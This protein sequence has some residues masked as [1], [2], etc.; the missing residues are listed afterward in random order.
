MRSGPRTTSDEDGASN[1]DASYSGAPDSQNEVPSEASMSE[2]SGDQVIGN[3]PQNTNA[4]TLARTLASNLQLPNLQP[5]QHA[6]LF[7]LSLI[8]GRCRTQAAN[9]VNSGRRAEDHLADDHPDVHDLAEVLFTKVSRELRQA[10][11]LPQELVIPSL[12]DLRRYSN[13]FD[14]LLLSNIATQQPPN[15]FE[16]SAFRAIATDRNTLNP[17]SLGSDGASSLFE[18]SQQ[19]PSN[20]YDHGAYRTITDSNLFSRTGD[21]ASSL[22]DRSESQALIAQAFGYN[23][24]PQQLYL[25]NLMV[26]SSVQQGSRDSNYARKFKEL[27]RLGKGGFGEVYRTQHF[28]D[29]QYYAV[30]KI[31]IT[32]AQLRSISSEVDAKP[33]LAELRALAHL[34]QRNVVRYFDSWI[35]TR[36]AARMGQGLISNEAYNSM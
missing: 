36:P 29:G 13:S 9:S 10:G 22:F 16:Q 21:A 19:Q 5:H 24:P 27:D 31:R 7:Y 1:M 3:V 17:V 4:G 28:L 6:S 25:S 23:M 11:M 34:Q 26:P 2:A 30:K 18:R 14:A 20:L 15:L 32:A 35:E 33:L 12:H 8:E